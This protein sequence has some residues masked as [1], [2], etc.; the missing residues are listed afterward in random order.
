MYLPL[1]NSGFC[2]RE[3]RHQ[4]L[5]WCPL[6]LTFIVHGLKCRDIRRLEIIFDCTLICAEVGTISELS[7]KLFQSH[8]EWRRNIPK[9][10]LQGKWNVIQSRQVQLGSEKETS[11][12]F[13]TT[14]CYCKASFFSSMTVTSS[15]VYFSDFDHLSKQWDIV[16]RGLPCKYFGTKSLYERYWLLCL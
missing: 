9:K 11:C 10:C 6:M 1:R 16:D 14:S 5:R 3:V 7:G 12:F 8:F 2:G 4:R 13:T 15:L